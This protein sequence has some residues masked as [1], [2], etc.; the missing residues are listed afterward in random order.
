[1]AKTKYV[2]ARPVEVGLG[3]DGTDVQ[4][5]EPGEEI[6]AAADAPTIVGLV[7]NGW[8]IPLD[9]YDDYIAADSP[10]LFRAALAAELEGKETA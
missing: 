9:S 10:E 5:F 7:A 1:M 6:P 4:H 3:V 8:A 2:A